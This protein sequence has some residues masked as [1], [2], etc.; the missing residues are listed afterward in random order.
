MGRKS[1]ENKEFFRSAFFNTL[2]S[3]RICG[4]H[5]IATC[6]RSKKSELIQWDGTSSTKTH[7]QYIWLFPTA[8]KT[9]RFMLLLSKKE[10][11]IIKEKIR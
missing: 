8:K 11:Y 4:A 10:Y 9:I 3:C 5:L 7:P 6:D 1:R 2:R